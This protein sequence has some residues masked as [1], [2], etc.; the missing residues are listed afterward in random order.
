MQRQ[1]G[2]KDR[3]VEESTHRLVFPGF[4]GV[5]NVFHFLFF[6]FRQ[7]SSLFFLFTYGVFKFPVRLLNFIY[8]SHGTTSE[9]DSGV[10]ILIS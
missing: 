1:V 2:I 4:R 5:R 8:P 3:R 9:F 7:V 10:V 6:S